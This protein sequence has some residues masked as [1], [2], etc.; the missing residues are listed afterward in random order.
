[1]KYV[2]EPEDVRGGR[3]VRNSG[4]TALNNKAMI[5]YS[6]GGMLSLA[7]LADG[8]VFVGCPSKEE[9]ATWLNEH[10]HEPTDDDS[11]TTSAINYLRGKR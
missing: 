3:V 8:L 9:L 2:W 6:P 4:T 10:G 11:E 7:S 5:C 1:M